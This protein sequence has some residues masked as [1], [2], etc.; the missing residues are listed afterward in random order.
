MKN[1]EQNRKLEDW[2]ILRLA[3]FRP[4]RLP[5]IFPF[6]FL[7]N[8]YTLIIFFK[9]SSNHF[10][11]RL[12]NHPNS[13][14]RSRTSVFLSSNGEI[15]TLK[16]GI[17]SVVLFRG[18][19]EIKARGTCSLSRP[20]QVH[21]CRGDRGTV[22]KTSSFFLSFFFSQRGISFFFCERR[23]A[24]EL[25]L[26]KIMPSLGKKLSGVCFCPVHPGIRSYLIVDDSW[27]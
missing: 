20:G 23:L 13:T 19:E 27:P 18:Q 25:F 15:G 2:R 8:Y 5:T 16:N 10:S 17:V 11:S 3:R 12:G 6:P 1:G 9:I 14:K 24:R 7:K 26:I 4:R 22:D 21:N